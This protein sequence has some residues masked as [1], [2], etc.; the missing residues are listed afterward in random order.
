MFKLVQLFAAKEIPNK[1]QQVAKMPNANC[2]N[3]KFV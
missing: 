2:K 3:A 1:A